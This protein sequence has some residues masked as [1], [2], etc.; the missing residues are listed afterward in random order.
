[1]TVPDAHTNPD[2]DRASMTNEKAEDAQCIEVV[3]TREGAA[4][5]PQD[6]QARFDLLRHLSPERMAE[7]NKS[8]VKK[9][10]WHMMPC[11]TLMFLMK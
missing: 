6:I 10:D 1:M 9:I 2:S 4:V 3:P 11:V 7:L 8:V 5:S